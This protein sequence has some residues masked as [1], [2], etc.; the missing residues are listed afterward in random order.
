VK[1]LEAVKAADPLVRDCWLPDIQVM[2]AR[3][4]AGSTASF[5]L[6]AKGGDNAASHNHN[7]VGN[8]I[9]YYNG[10]P[11]LIDA[12]AQT[13]TAATFSNKRYTLWN[14]QS[15][16]HNLPDINGVM[17]QNGKQY[18]AREVQYREDD[19][20][21]VFGLDISAA[22][23]AAAAVISWY[24]TLTL[25]RGSGVQLEENYRLRKWKA[26]VTENFLT[27]LVPYTGY[28]GVVRLKGDSL[29]QTIDLHYDRKAFRASV[30]TI[31][32][33]DGQLIAG[34]NRTGSR[35]GRMFRNWGP[36][37]YRVRLTGKTEKLHDKVTFKIN[38]DHGGIE[39]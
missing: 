1:K 35:N 6:A 2:A 27:P 25:N 15:A 13:Y 7:D 18:K 30:D 23:P 31:R 20:K 8:F 16:Y 21:A 38:R 33:H 10:Q 5:Y 36:V 4:V 12:G 28:P 26:P 11:V 9:V 14:N 17:Q 39:N 3:S 32:I 29:H 24:R 37:L 34:N 19:Q 22:Y